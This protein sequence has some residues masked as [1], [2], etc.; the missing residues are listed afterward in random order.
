MWAC[1]W[2]GRQQELDAWMAEHVPPMAPA[3]GCVTLKLEG[4]LVL[5]PM[6]L[7]MLDQRGQWHD[8]VSE[9]SRLGGK[10]VATQPE[11]QA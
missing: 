3:L 8:L 11:G 6:G 4:G 7:R 10:V 5:V 2:L 9:L 1:A